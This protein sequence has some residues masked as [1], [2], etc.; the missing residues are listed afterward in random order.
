MAFTLARRTPLSPQDAWA[1]V[2][3][4]GAHTAH[5]PLTTVTTDPGEPHVG[6]GFVAVTRAG[7]VGFDDP[8][9]L[10]AWEPPRRFRM[11]KT[12]RLLAGWADVTVEPDGSG[13]LV[14]WTEEICVRAGGLSGLTR[15]AGDRAAPRVFGPV[16]EGLLRDA[17]AAPR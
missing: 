12:G 5:V 3:D 10:T 1:A 8:M 9:F 16:V 2:T 11:V 17:E 14:T 7:P 4:F 15:R 13:S 6:W